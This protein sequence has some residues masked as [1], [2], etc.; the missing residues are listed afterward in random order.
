MEYQQL[1]LKIH[2]EIG[3]REGEANSLGNI[4]NLY[5]EKGESDETLRYYKLALKVFDEIGAS[6][7]IK[8]TKENIVNFELWLKQRRTIKR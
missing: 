4:G 5:G 2:R 8:K 7:N 3:N 1:A 6:E